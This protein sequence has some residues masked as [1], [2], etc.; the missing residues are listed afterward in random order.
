M[1]FAEAIQSGFKNYVNFNARASRSEYNY[2]ALFAILLTIFAYLLD[3]P[4]FYSGKGSMLSNILSLALALPGIALIIRRLHDT[5]KSGWNIL[6]YF[7]I[8]GIFP[9]FYWLVFKP[10][11]NK[12]NS[13]GPNPLITR[14]VSSDNPKN[15]NESIS[16]DSSDT[17][18][19]D[20]LIKLKRMLDDGLIEQEDY[21]G[22]KKELLGL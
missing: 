14:Q 22:K 17:N 20:E 21:D 7:T 1:N 13:Y 12:D 2:W 15:D 19:E 5:N 18:V 6:W 10:G 3:P 4:D 9:V 11:D 16:N 8:I